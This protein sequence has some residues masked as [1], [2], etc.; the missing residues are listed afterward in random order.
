MAT[1]FKVE[2]E[3][4]YE[5]EVSIILMF[6]VVVVVVVVVIVIVCAIIIAVLF[7]PVLS[8]LVCL[9][10][11]KMIVIEIEIVTRHSHDIAAVTFTKQKKLFKIVKVTHKKYFYHRISF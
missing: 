7:C 4:H 9:P 3:Q 6:V 10:N 1:F 5:I 2:N 11:E 8:C